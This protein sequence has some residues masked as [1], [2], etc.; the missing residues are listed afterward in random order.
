MVINLIRCTGCYGCVIKCKEEHLLPPGMT[1]AKVLISEAGTHSRIAK[2]M[3]PVLCNHCKEPSCAKACPT[4]ATQQD[5]NGIVWVDPDKCVGCRY[6]LIACPYQVRTYHAKEKEYFPGQGFTELEKVKRRLYPL[7]TGVVVKCTFCREKIDDAMRRGLKA[8]V[9]RE[10][11]PA[12]V[13][14][15]PTK[16]RVFGD[17][18]DPNS[19]VSLLISGRKAVQL[20]PEYGTDPSVY[21]IT[22]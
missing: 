19:E 10:A 11:T 1:W 6:C 13:N 17:L 20:R 9:D 8:G 12:C 21:Y 3:Y 15:C 5:D 7:Q 2:Q 22:G 14:L 16:A 4:G 18:D